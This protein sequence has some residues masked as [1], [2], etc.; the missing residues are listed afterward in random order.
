MQHILC[1]LEYFPVTAVG[2]VMGGFDLLLAFP[3]F[4]IY[5]P[6]TGILFYYVTL[7]ICSLRLNMARCTLV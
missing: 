4:R 1:L 6:S 3:T 5:F 2:P 7:Q